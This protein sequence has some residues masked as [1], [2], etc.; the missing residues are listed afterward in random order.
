M[1]LVKPKT[2]Y[3]EQ[4]L[5]SKIIYLKISESLFQ[6]QTQ[7][8][9]QS[10]DIKQQTI[11]TTLKINYIFLATSPTRKFFTKA[12]KALQKRLAQKP[13][14]QKVY[15]RQKNRGV[16]KFL[17]G[18]MSFFSI[19]ADFD[20]FRPT[21][22]QKCRNETKNLVKRVVFWVQDVFLANGQNWQKL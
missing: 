14:D 2:K 10:M 20:L 4:K 15:Q 21:K 6:H 13:N 9:K 17:I 16:K 18:D 7:H 8:N 5:V 11:T 19:K 12:K 1:E 22:D 3:R